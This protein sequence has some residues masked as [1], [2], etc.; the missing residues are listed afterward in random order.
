EV[1][2]T[3]RGHTEKLGNLYFL[4]GKDRADAKVVHAGDLVAAVKLKSTHTGDT[5]ADKARPVVLPRIP[6]PEP[7]MAEAIR[8]KAK[9]DGDKPGTALARV[10]EEDPTFRAEVD[11]V[12]HQTLVRGQGD[13][14]LEVSL[15]RIKRRYHVDVEMAKPRV[16]YRETI[17]TKAQGEYRHK[18]QPD[19]R[20]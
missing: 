4:V 10:H 19:G 18:K 7:V 9:G 13:L 1:L 3:T 8:P 17:R 2:N 6:F 11:G 20:G 12:M 15:E 16:A 14:H 5:L